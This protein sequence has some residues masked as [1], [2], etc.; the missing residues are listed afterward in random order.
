MKAGLTQYVAYMAALA[1]SSNCFQITQRPHNRDEPEI[2]GIT[3]HDTDRM[4]RAEKK[5][6]RKAAKRLAEI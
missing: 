6:N 5:R 4:E 2:K 1:S 3:E